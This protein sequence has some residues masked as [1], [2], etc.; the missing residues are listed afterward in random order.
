MSMLKLFLSKLFVDGAT[1]IA[2]FVFVV[3]LVALVWV[4]FFIY[5]P[6]KTEFVRSESELGSLKHQFS[7]L[8]QKQ[9]IVD[10]IEKYTGYL[11]RLSQKM[12]MGYST[13]LITTEMAAIFKKNNLILIN[14]SYQPLK[15]LGSMQYV[16]V[17]FS[18]SGSYE[19]I[20][21]MIQGLSELPFLVK[22][23]EA[24][25]EPIDEQLITSEMNVF[26]YFRGE[27]GS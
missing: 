16:E 25:L 23:T 18:F 8:Q 3:A 4:V 20:R 14:E 12:S 6:I 11:E 2:L 27:E 9:L 24:T 15:E 26:V 7:Q 13:S 22:V 21:S 5:L 17:L 1:R 19:D 10:D